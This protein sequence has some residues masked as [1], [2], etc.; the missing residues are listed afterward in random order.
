MAPYTFSCWFTM[1]HKAIMETMYARLH[2]S[3]MKWRLCRLSV[4]VQVS[5]RVGHGIYNNYYDCIF[6]YMYIT[7][8]TRIHGS[9]VIIISTFVLIWHGYLHKNKWTMTI[10]LLSTLYDY[11]NYNYCKL[12]YLRGSVLCHHY[13]VHLCFL[14]QVLFHLAVRHKVM[15]TTLSF[16][17]TINSSP[18]AEEADCLCGRSTC[19]VL[20]ILLAIT[21]FGLLFAGL[22][23]LYLYRHKILPLLSRGMNNTPL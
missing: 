8:N 21:V 10:F 22:V 3:T 2:Q 18:Y 12:W 23:I 14:V 15:Y 7:A 19:V 6:N 4:S 20:I 17:I 1:S 16:K 13:W 9:I 5:T 11:Y